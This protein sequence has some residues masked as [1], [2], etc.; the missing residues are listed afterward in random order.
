MIRMDDTNGRYDVRKSDLKVI[1]MIQQ[2]IPRMN[3]RSRSHFSDMNGK[4]DIRKSDLE[5]I[6]ILRTDDTASEK[7]IY[8]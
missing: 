5:V 2:K 8:K 1:L 4:C 6:L 3:K 7:A